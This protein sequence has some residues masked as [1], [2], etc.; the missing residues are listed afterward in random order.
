[1]RHRRQY[2]FTVFSAEIIGKAL[3][4]LEQLDAPKDE[5]G[6]KEKRWRLKTSTGNAD[7]SY[8]DLDEF[9]A[10]YRKR[11]D[12]AYVVYHIGFDLTLDV[13]ML[14]TTTTVEVTAPTRAN[15][16]SV[17]AVFEDALKE[18]KVPRPPPAP[19]PRPVIF[20]G[21]GHSPLWRD[22]KDHLHDQHGYRIEAYETG[23][24]AGHTIR[25]ILAELVRVSSFALL[26]LTAEDEHADGTMHARENVIHEAGLFQG[27]LRYGRAIVLLEAGVSEFSN[28]AGIHQIRFSRGNIRE[29]YGDVLATL[30]R[31]F[32]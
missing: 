8:D 30:R 4:Q 5:R 13:T 12:Y 32:G 29:T 22:L 24:R 20:I 25:D 10:E 19:P 11:P 18:S 28:I 1:M 17:F 9:F 27:R 2:F 21:H 15:I 6:P 3:H 14:E 31:E 26:V 7:W 16:E 23:A